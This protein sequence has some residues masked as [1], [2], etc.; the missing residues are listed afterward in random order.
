MFKD[1]IASCRRFCVPFDVAQLKPQKTGAS[2]SL[3]S[4]GGLFL[5]LNDRTTAWKGACNRVLHKLG[6]LV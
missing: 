5:L 2:S 3:G 6:R 1:N 4:K